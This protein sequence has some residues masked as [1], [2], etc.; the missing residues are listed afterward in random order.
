[1]LFNSFNFLVFFVLITI[2]YYITPHKLRWV[3]LL[4][5]SYYFYM[6][7]RPVFVIL[8]IFITFVNYISA[9]AVYMAKRQ[10]EKKGYLR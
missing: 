3:L 2:F 1:M 7:W 4:A 8:L 6:C 10:K 9:I 5:G